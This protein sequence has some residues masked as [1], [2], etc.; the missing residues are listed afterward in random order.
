MKNH[1]RNTFF[2]NSLIIII[3]NFIIKFLGLIN[4]ITITR[5]LG[6]SGM[7]L[8]VLSFPTIMLFVSMASFS[9]N[10][11]ISKLV[12]EA[13][14]TKIYSPK[15]ILKYS[16]LYTFI[17]A[18][19]IMIIY[20]ILLKP[21]TIIFL[22]NE[23]LYYPL[24]TGSPLILLVGLSDGLK[25]YF[26]GI[27]KVNIASF[28]SLI[29]QIGRTSFS[30]LSLI[31]MLPFGLIPATTFCL[32]SLSFGEL[33][34]IIF[35]L[36]KIKKYPIPDYNNTSNEKKAIFA[37][38]IPNTFSRLIGNFT[39]FLE[40]ILYTF[41]LGTLGYSTI[42]IQTNYTIIDAYTIPLLTFIVFLPQALS[43]AMIPNISEAYA[44]K[45]FTTIHYYIR[46]VLTFTFIPTIILSVNLF[47]NAKE[48]ML[49]IYNTTEGSEIIKYFVWFFIFY[50]LQIPIVAIL[51]A[52]GMSKKVFITSTINNFLRT[53][54]LLIFSLNKIINFN[55]LILAI[56]I[57]LIIG[58]IINLYQL[59]KSTHF[60]FNIRNIIT[61]LLITIIATSI[62]ILLKAYNI[63]YLFILFIT[64]CIVILLSLWQDFIWIE[65]IKNILKKRKPN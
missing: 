22:K 59:L 58:F 34:T 8:Y 48:F 53:I 56:T 25:G 32:L 26:I 64:S 11:T 31:I 42:D 10:I 54:L 20:I 61:L 12:S 43:T 33:C 28:A 19:V 5:L 46:K 38:S 35:T 2:I 15:K 29:E 44:L 36:I 7:S 50:Y 4:K 30:I 63:N 13:I 52:I 16:F 39:Y 18:L 45:K 49:L 41:A 3:T 21:L 51:Q 55:S 9:L 23:D 27:K 65:S 37:N 6:T 24:L 40:P 60:K 17:I 47:I 14:A 62:G 57:S 1:L